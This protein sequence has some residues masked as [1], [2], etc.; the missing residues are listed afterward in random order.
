MRIREARIG[1]FADFH[2]ILSF[3]SVFEF[4]VSVCAKIYF[5][6][7]DKKSKRVYT[8]YRKTRTVF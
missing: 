3:P 2:R 8:I 6:T 4:S 7:V 1:L 5:Y